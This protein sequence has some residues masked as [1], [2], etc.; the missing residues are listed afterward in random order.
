M[1]L[2]ISNAP[3]WAGIVAVVDAVPIL[4]T[5]TVL[6]PWALV[7]VLQGKQLMAIGLV[8]IYAC[9]YLTRTVLEPRMMGR[10]LGVDPLLMLVFLYIGYRFWG[11]WGL[12]FTPM[13]ASAVLNAARAAKTVD[14]KKGPLA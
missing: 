1:L 8:C 2:R 12:I 7:S 13:L 4:G 9:T 11:F 14:T 5:G 6:L 3:L 10:Y